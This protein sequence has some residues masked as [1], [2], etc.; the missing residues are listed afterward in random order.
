MSITGLIVRGRTIRAGGFSRTD[1][2][3]VIGARYPED[4]SIFAALVC[5]GRCVCVVRRLNLDVSI[6]LLPYSK[7][8]P[9]MCKE[10]IEKI[11][12]PIKLRLSWPG[13]VL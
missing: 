11:T 13:D 6:S 2:S 8:N 1:T 12:A 9:L 7:P 10:I 3:S 5:V 4:L